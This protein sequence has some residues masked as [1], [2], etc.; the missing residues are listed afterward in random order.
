MMKDYLRSE[1]EVLKIMHMQI[2]PNKNIDN[3]T[4]KQQ[5]QN[6]N[7]KNNNNNTNNTASLIECKL[8]TCKF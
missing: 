7:N 6:N 4:T 2:S 3:N 5:Q 1:K 8:E